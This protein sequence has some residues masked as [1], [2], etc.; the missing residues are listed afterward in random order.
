MHGGDQQASQ[1]INNGADPISGN[2]AINSN[3]EDQVMQQELSTTLNNQ[4][5][6]HLQNQ[7]NAGHPGPNQAQAAA[8]GSSLDPELQE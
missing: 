1:A 8:L 3:L 6:L 4:N 5:D 2:P 7:P